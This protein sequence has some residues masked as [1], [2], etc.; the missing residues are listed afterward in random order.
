MAPNLPTAA[1]KPCAKPRTREGK[2]SA[3]MMNVVAFGPKL[4]KNWSLF[5]LD[6]DSNWGEGKGRDGS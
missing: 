4:K 1:E 5:V 3:G 6:D 2:T